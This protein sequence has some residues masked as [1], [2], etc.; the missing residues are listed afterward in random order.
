M[1]FSMRIYVLILIAAS[2]MLASGYSQAGTA[3]VS[4]DSEAAA[5]GQQL[6]RE[7]LALRPTDEGSQTGTLKIRDG[8][9]RS[10]QLSIRFSTII[11]PT[12][13]VS[14]CFA[15]T[16]TN[17]VYQL[18]VVHVPGQPG[19]YQFGRTMSADVP[20]SVMA[21]IPAAEVMGVSFG[22]SD[23]SLADLGVE[24]FHWP[25]QRLKKREMRRGR[26][27]RVLESINPQPLPDG[28]SRVVSWIDRESL[29]VVF[30]EAYD[31]RGKLL[32]EFSPKDFK[33]VNGR[34]QLEEMEIRNVQ[35]GSRSRIVFD[36]ESGQ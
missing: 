7:V 33:K 11:T 21:E 3:T 19:A 12:N 20:V 25:E 31:A 2:C 36:L 35:T 22:G 15:A 23:F 8:N 27:C 4:S 17:E 13:W 14:V 5:E 32:K 29:G 18:N 24:F 6:A 16:E 26:S 30:A 10:T 28:Y 1:G 34:W 9:G